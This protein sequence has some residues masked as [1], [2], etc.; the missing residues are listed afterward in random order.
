MSFVKK[1]HVHTLN[2]RKPK[3]LCMFYCERHIPINV[4]SAVLHDE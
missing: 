1:E 3:I 4:F 2:S